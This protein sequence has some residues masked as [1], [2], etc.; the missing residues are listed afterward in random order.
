MSLLPIALL[1][2]VTA[3][4]DLQLTPREREAFEYL[5][6]TQTLEMP[7]VGFASQY[8]G[9]YLAL[10]ILLRSPHA[11]AALDALLR[12]GKLA[13]QL[14][15]L[16]GLQRVDPALARAVAK[17]YG[18]MHDTWVTVFSG[19]IMSPERVSDVVP[20]LGSLVAAPRDEEE[21]RRAEAEYDFSPR[22][23]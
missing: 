19:C 9:G 21:A 8:S 23:K 13:G 2:A 20:R 4:A 16:A 3:S 15:A 14:Y 6:R 10:R 7:T 18:S 5:R 22:R 11:A 1:L 17:R 12:D